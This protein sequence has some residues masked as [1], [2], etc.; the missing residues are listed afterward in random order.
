MKNIEIKTITLMDEVE[1]KEAESLFK[2]HKLKYCFIYLI[3]IFSF[4]LSLCCLIIQ[5]NKVVYNQINKNTFEKI[6]TNAALYNTFLVLT[7]IFAIASLIAVLIYKSKIK[8]YKKL[9]KIAIFNDRIRHEE[10][11]RENERQRIN[12]KT[13]YTKKDIDNTLKKMNKKN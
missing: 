11:I 8:P 2:H 4:I 9:V 5:S 1:T 7:I 6:N 10:R 3:P 12:E 13:D